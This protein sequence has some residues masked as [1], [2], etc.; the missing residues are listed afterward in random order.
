M[1]FCSWGTAAGCSPLTADKEIG[2]MR[3]R[4]EHFGLKVSG[5]AGETGQVQAGSVLQAQCYRHQDTAAEYL[6]IARPVL[7]QKMKRLGI[8]QEF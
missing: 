4:Y 7:Y 1:L 6:G 2:E 3:S 5:A 8:K